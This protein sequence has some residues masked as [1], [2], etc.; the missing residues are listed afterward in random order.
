MRGF[1]IFPRQIDECE[2]E[3]RFAVSFVKLDRAQKRLFGFRELLSQG[4]GCADAY[5][6]GRILRIQAYSFLI[7]LQRSDIVSLTACRIARQHGE[8]I[9][10]I[11]SAMGITPQ[12]F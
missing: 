3:P 7:R 2:I 6:R 8:A 12:V 4:L 11:I 1:V 10:A 9:H 5:E